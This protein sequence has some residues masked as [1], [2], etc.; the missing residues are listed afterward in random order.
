[1][2]IINHIFSIILCYYFNNHEIPFF[3]DLVARIA[4]VDFKKIFGRQKFTK[5]LGFNVVF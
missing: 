5:L 1:M 4:G 2:K 3:P